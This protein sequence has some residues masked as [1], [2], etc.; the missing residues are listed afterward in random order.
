MIQLR[1]EKK[2]NLNLKYKIAIKIYT[3]EKFTPV[4]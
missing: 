2:Q 4:S 1:K 3:P